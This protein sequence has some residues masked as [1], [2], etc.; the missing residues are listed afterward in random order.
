MIKADDFKWLDIVYH[1]FYLGSYMCLTRALTDCFL[2]YDLLKKIFR[3]AVQILCKIGLI[4]KTEYQLFKIFFS[5][6]IR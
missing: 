4:S 1:L 6:L 5:L 2:L 3:H